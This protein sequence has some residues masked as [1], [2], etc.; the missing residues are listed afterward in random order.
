VR[1]R[2]DLTGWPLANRKMPAIEQGTQR[3]TSMKYLM[4]VSSMVLGL[5]IPAL[6]QDAPPAADS[7]KQ[8]GTVQPPTNR[9]DKLVP[10]MKG[11]NAAASSSESSSGAASGEGEHPPTNR[12]GKNVPDMKSPNA[13][14]DL[15]AEQ[16][17]QPGQ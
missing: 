16:P 2:N 9:L 12:I 14:S 6:A 1:A 17:V 15:P 5:A 10:P 4:I 13:A 7:A 11:P 3:R 8:Q